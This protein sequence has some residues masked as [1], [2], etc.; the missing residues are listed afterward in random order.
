MF[1]T[2]AYNTQHF[3]GGAIVIGDPFIKCVSGRVLFIHCSS[4]TF[5]AGQRSTEA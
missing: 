1:E 3:W 2:V 4:S 5:V